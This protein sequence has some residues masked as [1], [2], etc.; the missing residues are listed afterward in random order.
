MTKAAREL[1]ENMLVAEEAEVSSMKV[2]LQLRKLLFKKKNG[3]S[4]RLEAG[5]LREPQ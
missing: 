5:V 2:Q 4:G 1:H 3:A